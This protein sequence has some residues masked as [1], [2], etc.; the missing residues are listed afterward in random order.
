MIVAVSILAFVMFDALSLG[1]GVL[2]EL[3]TLGA[4]AVA[5]AGVVAAVVVVVVALL[6]GRTTSLRTRTFGIIVA[7]VAYKLAARTEKGTRT[8]DLIRLRAPLFGDL[9]RKSAISRFS[10][11]LGTSHGFLSGRGR[12]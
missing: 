1:Y 9:T 8:M 5:V 7:V 10:R 3:V 6:P 2:G 4:G 11:T 12:K